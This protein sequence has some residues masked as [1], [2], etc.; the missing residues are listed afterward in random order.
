MSESNVKIPPIQTPYGHGFIV[1]DVGINGVHKYI[2]A[3]LDQPDMIPS[4]G[5]KLIMVLYSEITRVY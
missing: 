4:F 1:G 3:L 5:P 2:V